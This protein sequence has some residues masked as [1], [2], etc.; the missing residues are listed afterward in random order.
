MAVYDIYDKCRGKTPEPAQTKAL[1]DVARKEGRIG[2][3]MEEQWHERDGV[4]AKCG[5]RVFHVQEL[6]EA[7][8]QT[9]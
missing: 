6:G 4:C 2:E 5:H 1:S 8:T 7:A 3:A 9:D